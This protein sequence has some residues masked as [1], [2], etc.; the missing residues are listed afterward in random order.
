M[1]ILFLRF[2]YFMS[3]GF[4][5]AGGVSG[6]QHTIRMLD[7]PLIVIRGVVGHNHNRIHLLEEAFFKIG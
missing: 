4:D 2:D 1:T 6:I 5:L 7:D 3:V